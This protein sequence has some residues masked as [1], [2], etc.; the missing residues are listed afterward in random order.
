[1]SNDYTNKPRIDILI[2]DDAALFRNFVKDSVK[3]VKLEANF[4]E[5]A[6]GKDLFPKYEKYV[7][8]IAIVDG[9]LEGIDVFDTVKKIIELHPIASIILS[10]NSIRH[11]FM[12]RHCRLVSKK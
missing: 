2:A 1:M 10:V 3:M 7:P 5:V 11:S 12:N 4:I 6:K 9:Y 8:E